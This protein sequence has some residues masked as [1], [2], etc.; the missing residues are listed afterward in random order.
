MAY[1][2]LELITESLRDVGVIAIDE[3]ASASDVAIALK[4]L[5]WMLDLWGG[6][7]LMI[8]ANVEESFALVGGTF[9]YTIGLVGATVVSLKPYKITHAFVRDS[10][11]NDSDL[12]IIGRDEYNSLSD[13]ISSTGKPE[14]LCYD[15]GATQQVNHIGTILI[16]PPPDSAYTL[17]ISSEKALTEIAA[18]AANITFE[19]VYYEALLYNLDKRLWPIYHDDGKP[20]RLGILDL[21]RQSK[22]V[23][24]TLNG[25]AVVSR[26]DIPSSNSGSYNIYNDDYNS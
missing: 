2:A 12:N 24:E 7:N 21:A 13:K 3:P 5:N 4:R 18:P 1:T 26:T 6:T 16:N 23:L 9:S 8:R 22:K 15:P 19:P 17:Y 11:G 25:K 20:C 10:S 14:A